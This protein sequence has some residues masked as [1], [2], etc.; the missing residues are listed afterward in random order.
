MTL[1]CPW[2]KRPYLGW[3]TGSGAF[4][5]WYCK[6]HPFAETLARILGVS[7][8]DALAEARKYAG[9]GKTTVHEEERDTPTEAVLPPGT[10]E[11]SEQQ[12]HYLTKRG[13]RDVDLLVETW[14]VKGVSYNGG[15][16]ANR[17]LL[18]AVFGDCVVSWTARSIFPGAAVRYLSCAEEDEAMP[19]K[20]IVFGWQHITSETDPVV[21]VEGPFDAMKLGPGA[22]AT[23]GTAWT[24]AQMRLLSRQRRVLILYDEEPVAQRQAREL[25][26]GLSLLGTDAVVV[27]DVGLKDP[28]EMPVNDARLLMQDLLRE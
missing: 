25:A 15:R 24:S 13:F 8:S 3:H 6:G 1:H 17:I 5:C 22:I 19:I 10:G 4:H 12:C 14:G 26:E 21:V 27:S 16:Y 7:V 20:S 18:P 28:G 23:L 11:L 9:A 2:C